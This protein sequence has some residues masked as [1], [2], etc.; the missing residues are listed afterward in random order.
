MKTNCAAVLCLNF[1]QLIIICSMLLILLVCVVDGDTCFGSATRTC[2]P[3]APF[4]ELLIETSNSKNFDEERTLLQKERLRQRCDNKNVS[5]S[6]AKVV[7]SYVSEFIVAEPSLVRCSEQLQILADVYCQLM[8]FNLVLN[9][10]AELCFVVSLLV[11]RVPV[12]RRTDELNSSHMECDDKTIH[13]LDSGVWNVRKCT[14]FNTVHNCVYFATSVL[15]QQRKILECFDKI[16]LKMLADNRYISAFMPDLYDFIS[17]LV[18]ADVSKTRTCASSVAA[19][20]GNV[21]FQSDTDNRQNFPTDQAF[22]I[23]RKQRDGFYDILRTWE[24]DH[25]LPNWSFAV[26]L[27]PRIR[28]LLSL[29]SEPA[30]FVHFARLFRSQL[31]GTCN[32][33]SS[34]SVS[35][36]CVLS[37]N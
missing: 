17:G 32:G 22:N 28:A 24:A 8:N 10:M 1:W 26:A 35:V 4:C 16:T 21:S 18:T 25:M 5:L 7:G 19:I 2:E 11:V 13:D 36:K 33:H 20:Q 31:L 30:N 15:N 27:G 23:F 37:K 29:H 3:R 34:S 12:G 9:I 14:Y 6:P